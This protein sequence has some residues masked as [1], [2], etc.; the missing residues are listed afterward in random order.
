MNTGVQW[1]SICR[2]TESCLQLCSTPYDMGHTAHTGGKAPLPRHSY[3][4]T[5]RFI[6]LLIFH[7]MYTYKIHTK[8]TWSVR[9]HWSTWNPFRSLSQCTLLLSLRGSEGPRRRQCRL[10]VSGQVGAEACE[11]AWP[12][13]P[14]WSAWT[15]SVSPHHVLHQVIL[16][17][18]NPPLVDM[19]HINVLWG[20]S[21]SI[22]SAAGAAGC[23]GETTRCAQDGWTG[24][25]FCIGLT[26]L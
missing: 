13:P 22:G 25:P 12:S 19:F 3:L 16:L 24:L 17:N 15:P 2:F 7:Y 23:H 8:Y 14:W 4:V 20:S 1:G 11:G 26:K 6:G 9:M 10:V 5:R 18:N 21:K